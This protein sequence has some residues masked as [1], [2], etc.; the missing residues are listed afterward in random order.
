M[1]SGP[2]LARSTLQRQPEALCSVSPKHPAASAQ[3]TLPRQ[4]KAPDGQFFPL[5]TPPA[6][7][8]SNWKREGVTVAQPFKG[9]D[10]GPMQACRLR[11]SRYGVPRRSEA[12][13]EGLRCERPQINGGRLKLRG[14][15]LWRST[16]NTS[17]R[18]GHRITLASRGWPRTGRLGTPTRLPRSGP[19]RGCRAW[20]RVGDPAPPGAEA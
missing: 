4:R 11:A 6:P 2:D 1:C 5:S 17:T 9:C 12:K 8:S 10:G 16:S 20:A 3:S 14:R 19:T 18:C 7:F 13:R 15:G